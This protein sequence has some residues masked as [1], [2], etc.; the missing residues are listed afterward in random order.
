[1]KDF[2]G[3]PKA[4][5][6][7]Y[8]LTKF[9]PKLRENERNW[10]ERFLAPS[11]APTNLKPLSHQ[12]FSFTKKP[13]PMHYM[14]FLLPC[15]CNLFLHFPLS[16][17]LCL[18]SHE[19]YIHVVAVTNKMDASTSKHRQTL[20]ALVVITCTT[21]F[22]FL[23]FLFVSVHPLLSTFWHKEYKLV[24]YLDCVPV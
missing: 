21:R 5:K 10:T 20:G 22:S 9:V 7:T 18:F 3:A 17:F 16:S 23:P 13:T 4:G 8:Y 19:A 1:M 12:R 14:N 6:P 24:Q 2:S 15:R 11:F